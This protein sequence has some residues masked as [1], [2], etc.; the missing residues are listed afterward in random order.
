MTFQLTC[1]TIDDT[2]PALD[3]NRIVLP[4]LARF[5][6]ALTYCSATCRLAALLPCCNDK[7]TVN[8][9]L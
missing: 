1:A 5:P 3:G 4:S 8:K 7:I 6:N 9:L 2:S